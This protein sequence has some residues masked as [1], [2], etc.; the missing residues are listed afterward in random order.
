ML[1]YKLLASYAGSI[2]VAVCVLS[3]L[4]HT[5]Y[6]FFLMSVTAVSQAALILSC[7]SS[8]CRLCIRLSFALFFVVVM[9]AAMIFIMPA[10]MEAA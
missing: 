1:S 4:I 10:V 9:E 5:F 3:S 6:C 2:Q 8:V 7:E